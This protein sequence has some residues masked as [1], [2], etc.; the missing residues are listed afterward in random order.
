[1][2]WGG[3]GYL[4]D[5]KSIILTVACTIGGINTCALTQDFSSPGNFVSNCWPEHISQLPDADVASCVHLGTA[6]R[7][8]EFGEIEEE[9]GEWSSVITLRGLCEV[10]ECG[11]E[12]PINLNARCGYTEIDEFCWSVT[13]SITA[14]LKWALLARI[15]AEAELGGSFSGCRSR[16]PD[17][18]INGDILA[19]CTE[20]DC[21]VETVQ[22]VKSITV[23]EYDEVA[24]WDCAF[25]NGMIISART[26]CNHRFGQAETGRTIRTRIWFSPARPISP[27]VCPDCGADC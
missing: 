17:G 11:D 12:P 16:V 20:R 8:R 25:P 15:G 10:W 19:P 3:G 27:N 18:G 21:N 4:N 13:G 5:M 22:V 1:M 7:V 24:E 14:E 26:V 23:D 2:G 6:F 9:L